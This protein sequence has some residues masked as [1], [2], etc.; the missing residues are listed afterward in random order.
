MNLL[1]ITGLLISLTSSI[2]ILIFVIYG[3][4]K[5]HRLWTLVNA[6]VLA[7]GVGCFLAGRATSPSDALFAWRIAISG[8]LFI[9]VTFYHCV[10]IFSAVKKRNTLLLVYLQAVFFFLL[11][12]FTESTLNNW[13]KLFGFVYYN[14]ANF[15]YFIM[16]SGWVFVSY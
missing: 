16:V 15:V 5:L 14:Q 1:S 10:C 7:W 3:R 11:T 12:I 13:H 6:T 2:L 8:G 9:P 4:T